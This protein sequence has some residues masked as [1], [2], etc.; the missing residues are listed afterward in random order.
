MKRKSS[1]QGN[2]QK[3]IVAFIGSPV[4]E[5]KEELVALGT[6]LQKFNIALDVVNFGEE[7]QNT[8]KLE[9][10][11]SAANSENNSRLVTVPQGPH[12]LSDMILKS[13]IVLGNERAAEVAAQGGNQ[14]EFGV[15]P[16]VD[17]ELAMALKLS[18][19]EENK[20]QQKAQQPASQPTTSAP[21]QQ[22]PA[23]PQQ[24][25]QQDD[26]DI[27]MDDEDAINRAIAMSLLPENQQRSD[28]PQP[29]DEDDED[30]KL[31][32]AL[33][34]QNN[35][36]EDMTDV[37]EDDKFLNDAISSLGAN[38]DEVLKKK[39]EDEDKKK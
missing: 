2:A 7:E 18:M 23:Q 6:E 30:L 17:P 19:E 20:R 1:E 10:L 28:A 32:L 27:D 39:K 35:K 25:Q 11:V 8:E 26:D 13:P 29:M 33:S 38:P 24:A 36:S 22:A 21:S 9:A 12:I 14:F 15:D 5:S 34:K 4:K 37:L 16:T 3:R 31:A